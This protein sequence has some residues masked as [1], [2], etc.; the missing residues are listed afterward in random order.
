MNDYVEIFVPGRLCILGEHS[1]WAASYRE[2]NNDIEKGYAIVAGLNLGIYIKGCKAEGF[3]YEYDNER[4]NISCIDLF[5]YEDKGFLEY[6]VASAKIMHMKYSVNGVKIICE[7]MTLP[8]KKGLASSAAVCVA[9]IRTYNKLYELGLSIEEEMSLAY[10]A[11]RLTG[12]KC[13][14]MDQICAF[15]QGIRKICF[16]GE[17]VQVSEI[18]TK[19]KLHFILV[20]LH[21]S[22]NTK[23]ILRELN[24]IYPFPKNH[25][26]SNLLYTLGGFNKK[27]I[28]DAIN[29]IEKGNLKLLGNNL[30]DFQKK[31]DENVACFSRELKAPLLH[32]LI[33]YTYN[34]EGVLACKGVGSQGDGMAQI[35]VENAEKAENIAQ[36]IKKDFSYDCYILD[37]EQ[38]F[39]NAIIP[40]AGKGT[41]M[42][43]FTKI[44]DKALLPIIDSG[45]IYPA[46]VLILKELYCSEKIENV[47]LIINRKQKDMIYQLN[48][49][50]M[51]ENIKID[52]L[53]TTQNKRGFGGAIASSKFG[54]NSGFSMVCLGDYVYRGKECGN[55]TRQL[56]DFWNKYKQP[57][58]GIKPINVNETGL[59]GVVYG[60]W[61]DDR[62]LKIEKIIEKPDSEYAKKHLQVNYKG[63]KV[64]F[65]FFG[66]YIINN[67]IIRTM[68]LEDKKI[69]IGFSEYLNIYAQN[70]PMYAL[71][72][73]G[74][75][76]DLGNPKDYYKSFVE[77]G[78]IVY[79]SI[80]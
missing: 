76:F 39:L 70:N 74:E 63:N 64:V 29:N 55:C 65:A 37:I 12:S 38:Q 57:V 18:K 7:K 8:I 60:R 5:K 75:S 1:D 47:E 56:I 20:D 53:E 46:L 2:T 34:V 13:G 9:I 15:G 66:E 71:V 52:I 16:D 77:Y 59:Y 33:E 3:I 22:K 44:V 35:L 41:R 19:R 21:G 6:V 36:K 32:K 27:N 28:I 67:D 45:R 43:P 30:R 31:F 24:A 40:I 4:I 26:E 48:S 25:T 14:K 80:R 69:D 79:E 68:A 72:I 10:E 49:I 54:E 11:E 42:Y 17:K 62:V 58:V 73:E 23:K 50:L 78:R 51:D 61:V